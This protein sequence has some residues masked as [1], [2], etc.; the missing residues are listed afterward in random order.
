MTEISPWMHTLPWIAPLLFMISVG[1]LAFFAIRVLST[2]AEAYSREY[3]AE[4]ARQL[5]DMF[6]FIPP[7]HILDLAVGCAL[8]AF[9]IIFLAFGGLTP[10]TLFQ[11]LL[12][13]LLAGY[14]AWQ[15]PDALLRIAKQRRLQRFN[16]QLVD[17]LMNMSNALKAGFSILQSFETVV[18][19]GRNP[20][21]QEFG[22]FLHQVRIGVNIDDALANLQVRVGSEDLTLMVSAIEIARQ[23]GG[24]LTEVFE[25]IAHTIR[26]RMRIETR[27]RTLTAMGRLQAIVIGAMPIVLG[28]A[29][30][31]LDPSMMLTFIHSTFGMVILGIAAAFEV[32]GVLIIRRII[33]ID[34]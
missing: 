8:T 26:E 24:N 4:A 28:L 33:R 15:L 32:I 11:G 16:E 17:S 12:L 3:T 34:V 7:R 31:F 13:G 23:T 19:Q 21:S 30:F 20:I 6:L 14:A 10:N 22:V 29:V 2:G 18:R 25:K 27:I 9:V 1:G 5:E